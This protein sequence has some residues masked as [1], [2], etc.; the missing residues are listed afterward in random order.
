MQNDFYEIEFPE[1]FSFKKVTEAFQSLNI[2]SFSIF[3]HWK[4]SKAKIIR[5]YMVEQIVYH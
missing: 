3:R 4:R 2:K 1:L 5:N